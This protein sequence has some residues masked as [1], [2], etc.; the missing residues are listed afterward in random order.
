MAK[1]AAGA[2]PDLRSRID[3]GMARRS[4]RV[5]LKHQ[6]MDVFEVD[7]AAAALFHLSGDRVAPGAIGRPG[8]WRRG[9]GTAHVEANPASED[10]DHDEVEL[11]GPNRKHQG[12]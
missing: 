9:R 1:V 3:L 2:G 4:L 7:K 11:V 10:P 6:R 5:P 8:G 12:A